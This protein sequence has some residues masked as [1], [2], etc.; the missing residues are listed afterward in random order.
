MDTSDQT[1]IYGD[2]KHMVAIYSDVTTTYAKIEKLVDEIASN[3]TALQP[4]DKKVILKLLESADKMVDIM[5]DMSKML[6][7]YISPLLIVNDAI[8]TQ[9]TYRDFKDM[10]G[11]TKNMYRYYRSLYDLIYDVYSDYARAGY[12]KNVKYFKGV[13]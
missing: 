2:L 9:L 3:A 7:G 12:Y 11:E 8:Y 5:V 1:K 10:Y 13:N 4:E 6:D